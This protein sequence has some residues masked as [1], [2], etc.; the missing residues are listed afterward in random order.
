MFIRRVIKSRVVCSLQSQLVES[1]FRRYPASLRRS[2]DFVA[3]RVASNV[4]K[5]LQQTVLKG[6]SAECQQW[7]AAHASSQLTASTE[8]TLVSLLMRCI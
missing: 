1:F 7:A 4:I 3:E 8:L 6:L 2:A 5:S